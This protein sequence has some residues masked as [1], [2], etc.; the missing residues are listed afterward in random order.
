MRS[1]RPFVAIGILL[2]LLPALVARAGDNPPPPPTEPGVEKP[3]PPVEKPEPPPPPATAQPARNAPF[4][5]QFTQRSE[6]STNEYIARRM[7][8][9]LAAEEAAKVD[10]NLPDESFEVYVPADY[11]AEKPFGLLAFVNPHPSGRPPQQYV[12]LLDKYHLIYVGANKAG[13][14][15]FVRLRMGLTIDAVMNIRAQYKIDPDRIYVSGIS[16]GGRTASMLGVGFADVFRG[17]FYIIGCN[18][19]KQVW[20]TEQKGFYKKSY[21]APPAEIYRAARTRS[22]H[23]FL[24]GDTDGN[25]DQT[26]LYYNGFKSDNFEHIAFFQV[27]GM[28]HQPPPVDWF[29][30][31]LIAL[32][33]TVPPLG[34]APAAKPAAARVAPTTKPAQA[35]AARPP[36][37]AA[38]VPSDPE[39][40]AH[41][42]LTRAKLYVDNHQAELAREKL[43]WIVDHYP[44][45]AAARDAKK[46]LADPALK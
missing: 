43:R 42:L 3:D 8:W 46:L 10:Y 28:G 33:E 2:L 23:V 34:S 41:G 29:E 25:R 18:Y 44:A 32:D 13:N 14:D 21:Y 19:Y 39:S 22:K 20:S 7:G 26:T 30:K 36:A 1:T 24:T 15:R 45:T 4:T 11:N 31:G 16:G 27:P 5:L 37:P 17:G 9:P 40:I 6:Q 38:T 12:H 35:I